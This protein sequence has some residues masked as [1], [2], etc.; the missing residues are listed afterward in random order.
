MVNYYSTPSKLVSLEPA[1][2][3]AQNMAVSSPPTLL[4]WNTPGSHRYP[5]IWPDPTTLLTTVFYSN[6]AS[7]TA[8]PAATPTTDSTA[9]STTPIHHY[10]EYLLDK[11]RGYSTQLTRD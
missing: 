1:L 3:P 9:A 11:K 8:A 5:W 2:E 4:K 6:M 10:F 7:F